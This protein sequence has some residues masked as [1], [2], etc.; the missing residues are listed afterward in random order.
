MT[1]NAQE[2]ELQSFQEL[3]LFMETALPVSATVI[4]TIGVL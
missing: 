2:G 3:Q 1:C 4:G